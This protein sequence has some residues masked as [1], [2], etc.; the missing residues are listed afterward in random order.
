MKASDLTECFFSASVSRTIDAVHPNTGLGVWGGRSLEET[1]KE[2]PD[3]ERV[4]F[5]VAENAIEA[6]AIGTPDVVSKADWWSSYEQLPPMKVRRSDCGMSAMC[7]EYLVG[8]VTRIHAVLFKSPGSSHRAT[9]FMWNDVDTLT[10]DEIMSRCRATDRRCGMT[11]Q[12][13]MGIIGKMIEQ[14]AVD[15]SDAEIERCL[16]STVMPSACIARAKRMRDE[17]RLRLGCADD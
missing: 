2:Y 15:T 7:P 8:R 11:N 10:H 4:P 16:K 3:A 1:R 6:R 9:Y 17:G 12:S 14:G 13:E 5:E